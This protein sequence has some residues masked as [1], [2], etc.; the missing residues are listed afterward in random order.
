[1]SLTN[2]CSGTEKPIFVEGLNGFES[3]I[4]EMACYYSRKKYD[5]VISLVSPVQ[6]HLDKSKYKIRFIIYSNF[7][8][9]TASAFFQT[10]DYQ[11]CLHWCMKYVNEK[12]LDA[13]YKTRV[14]IL[15]FAV[16]C[17][18]ELNNFDLMDS[19]IRSAFRYFDKIEVPLEFEK[20]FLKF[21]NKLSSQAHS[22]DLPGE[23]KLML[24]KLRQL[25]DNTDKNASPEKFE[26]I[27]Y[28][29]NKFSGKVLA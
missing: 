23:L 5:R 15:V 11:N 7:Y 13:H 20:L 26:L 14:T 4:V 6:E 2:D 25:L 3:Y 21:F 17:N 1:M 18:Y 22:K 28:L 29:E 16:I 19:L 24:K 8:R 9:Y 10:A 27:E 12:T